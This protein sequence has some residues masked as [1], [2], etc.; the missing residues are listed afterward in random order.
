MEGIKV[1]VVVD[2]FMV[3]MTE[4]PRGSRTGELSVKSYN[5][6]RSIGRRVQDYKDPV[7]EAMGKD[8]DTSME[9]DMPPTVN[10]SS[11]A[12]GGSQ[13]MGSESTQGVGMGNGVDFNKSP[14]HQKHT[15]RWIMKLCSRRMHAGDVDGDLFQV[16]VV[17][18]GSGVDGIEVLSSV[19]KGQ[20]DSSESRS[21]VEDSIL[22]KN[23]SENIATVAPGVDRV[24]AEC[25]NGDDDPAAELL[26][27]FCKG[28]SELG[29]D[30]GRG[31][32]DEFLN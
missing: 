20:S 28:A 1:K 27:K 17:E 26:L 11:L 16:K 9:G 18:E 24:R 2:L 3:S 8:S 30:A 5:G 15:F 25:Q 7:I 22:G 32:L 13:V 23:L 19:N 21:Y 6:N 14:I 31:S 12:N 10:G 4:D 29:N